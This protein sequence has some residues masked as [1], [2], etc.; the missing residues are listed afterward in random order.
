MT[1]REEPS[2]FY[3]QLPPDISELVAKAFE[4]MDASSFPGT[5]Y[6]EV[7]TPQEN[8]SLAR[9]N[10]WI[11]W[12]YAPDE[13]ELFDRLDWRKALQRFLMAIGIATLLYISI[14][15]LFEMALWS[16]LSDINLLFPA[17]FVPL[18][19]LL[20]AS[21]LSYFFA[22]L[23]FREARQRHLARQSGPHRVT[24]GSPHLFDQDMWMA[25]EHI[26]LQELF[27]KLLKVELSSRPPLVLSLHRRLSI[28]TGS[29]T[30][31]DTLYLPVPQGRE[32][33]ASQLVERF[34]TET[35]GA[36]KKKYIPAEPE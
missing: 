17:L 24:I 23:C 22:W 6:R 8:P 7:F 27:I 33:E 28:R 12:E 16:S 5:T 10:Y 15:S 11:R 4:A 18:M 32:D 13:W 1:A 31:R 2:G 19:L 29:G 34:R 3:E 30:W 36:G 21:L 35:I 20:P 14:V 9:P 25:G 26:P